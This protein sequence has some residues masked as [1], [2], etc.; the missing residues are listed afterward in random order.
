MLIYDNTHWIEHDRSTSEGSLIKVEQTDAVYDALNLPKS[1]QT[2]IQTILQQAKQHQD[3]CVSVAVLTDSMALTRAS[4]RQAISRLKERGLLIEQDNF[5]YATQKKS[6]NKLYLL[7]APKNALTD[8]QN[9]P[10]K[11][12]TPSAAR[13]YPV[14]TS[15][16]YPVRPLDLKLESVSVIP[17]HSFFGSLFGM[18]D[19][20]KIN[21]M[22]NLPPNGFNERYFEKPITLLSDDDA[23]TAKL[24]LT[25]ESM[26]G[27]FNRSHI[28]FLYA[29][30]FLS[31]RYH[32]DM[33][34][35]YESSNGTIKN[36]TPIHTDHL[37]SLLGK[38]GNKETR[39][40]IVNL[41]KRIENTKV[42]ISCDQDL[43]NDINIHNTL[44][45][46]FEVEGVQFV[47]RRIRGA[48]GE[49][50]RNAKGDYVYKD[51]APHR[52]DIKW[53]VSVLKSIFERKMFYLLPV[54][55]ISYHDLMFR[56]Y[57]FC[58]GQ[59]THRNRLDMDLSLLNELLAP[60]LTSKVFFNTF[61]KVVVAHFKARPDDG[62]IEVTSS[63]TGR[64]LEKRTYIRGEF[65]G[66]SGYFIFE[67]IKGVYYINCALE[68][69]ED[70]IFF[71]SHSE[72]TRAK[73]STLSGVEKQSFLSMQKLGNK[74]PVQFNN[75][76]P[77]IS[78]RLE[79]D[80]IQ[81]NPLPED[82]KFK[83]KPIQK[84]RIDKRRF[85]LAITVGNAKFSVSRYS[86]AETLLAVCDQIHRLSLT[87]V[88]EIKER[89]DNAM[90]EVEMFE[91][92]Q[93]LIQPQDLEQLVYHVSQKAQKT[94]SLDDMVSVLTT[95][96][97]LR[98]QA[99]NM[100]EQIFSAL[101][102][103]F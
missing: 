70:K 64:G 80:V 52:Y 98:K 61:E 58:R 75:Q 81:L 41:F 99:H 46:F 40:E 42:G 79:D 12:T 48:D 45:R 95:N 4:V 66:I 23:I 49:F 3:H 72:G 28:R 88:V 10:A 21:L 59:S 20:Q 100:D 87:P 33:S 76:L 47:R 51:M 18:P 91:S 62:S 74:A 56:L 5:Q 35:I 6:K 16:V 82:L 103:K 50:L 15:P 38:S 102:G 78:H 97:R 31:I 17:D 37:L 90:T 7:P 9:M 93:G 89:I 32:M 71:Y 19:S 14:S 85:S 30:V 22:N 60:D 96:T 68:L 39:D 13:K 34:G 24:F 73:L 29:L 94:I 67:R 26:D 63:G 43:G 101:V 57:L 54:E 77:G 44:A 83:A 65:S 92:S 11:S 69:D 1:A 2:F 86:S 53:R 55:V 84:I 25:T 36:I 27:V 8:Q